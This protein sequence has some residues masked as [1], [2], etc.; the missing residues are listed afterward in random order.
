[1][2]KLKP[3]SAVTR[4]LCA[5]IPSG[6]VRV[7]PETP[8]CGIG[9]EQRRVVLI[10]GNAFIQ[11]DDAMREMMLRHEAHHIFCNHMSRR[12]EREWDL[13]NQVCD[14]A[15]HY[16][17]N[18]NPEMLD[19]G[20]QGE[21]VTYERLGIPPMPPEIAYAKLKK[22]QESGKPPPDLQGCGSGQHPEY[23]EGTG[24]DGKAPTSE[25]VSVVGAIIRG[26]AEEVEEGQ[27]HPFESAESQSKEQAPDKCGGVGEGTGMGIAIKRLPPPPEWVDD[28]MHKLTKE[29]GKIIYGRSYKREHRHGNPFLPGRGRSRRWDGVFV[30]DAS[31]SINETALALMLA[32]ICKTPELKDATVQLFDSRVGDP[33]C[34]N[35]VEEI[36]DDVRNFRGGT[37]IRGAGEEIGTDKPRVWFTDCMSSD[38]FPD[39]VD[40]DVW[41]CFEGY[42]DEPVIRDYP[43]ERSW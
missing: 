16:Q 20:I 10:V 2:L 21:V 31:G 25:W 33:W 19:R 39:R 12:Q 37:S 11:A 18:V 4:S 5:V 42:G 29:R 6:R 28:L 13:W 9:M 41:V 34:A 32:A 35:Q 36:M 7:E 8:T 22:E 17:T 43:K 23:Q 15:I 40:D 3:K 30:V 26:A 14:A 24:A 38:G 1:M 27:P